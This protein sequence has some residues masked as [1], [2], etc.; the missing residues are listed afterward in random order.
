MDSDV[1]NVQTKWCF[2]FD[3]QILLPLN[4]ATLAVSPV[5]SVYAK[6]KKRLS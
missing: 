4:I 6:L 5:S 3:V 2:Y 1:Q